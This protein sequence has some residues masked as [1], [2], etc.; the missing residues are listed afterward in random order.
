[1]VGLRGKDILALDAGQS[2]HGSTV[3]GDDNPL[4]YINSF[5]W[6]VSVAGTAFLEL[7]SGEGSISVAM[8]MFPVPVCRPW[9]L[10]FDSRMDV[11]KM[12]RCYVI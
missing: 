7:F 8:S 9:D 6:P 4:G 5:D 3:I 12:C 2:F 1:M 10:A 11:T